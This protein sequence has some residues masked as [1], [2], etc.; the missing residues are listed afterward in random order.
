MGINKHKT[1]TIQVISILFYTALTLFVSTGGYCKFKNST[2]RSSDAC[3]CEEELYIWAQGGNTFNTGLK[4]DCLEKYIGPDILN[5][6]HKTNGV[7]HYTF[8]DA[9][10]KAKKDCQSQ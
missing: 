5:V 4:V 1:E 10:D 8:L 3:K 2:P 6:Y 9:W 7:G